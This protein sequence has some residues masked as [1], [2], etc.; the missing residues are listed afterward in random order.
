[1][2]GAWYDY[3]NNLLTRLVAESEG[4][5]SVAS[6]CCEAFNSH[7][8]GSHDHFQLFLLRTL[9]PPS[10]KLTFPPG[11]HFLFLGIKHTIQINKMPTKRELKQKVKELEARLGGGEQ[12]PNETQDIVNWLYDQISAPHPLKTSTETMM[13]WLQVMNAGLST[14]N[15]QRRMSRVMELWRQ[16]RI[17]NQT[18]TRQEQEEYIAQ[19]T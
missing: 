13:M 6:Q 12:A 8:H 11:A 4:T 7:Q 19:N 2:F 5:R 14:N 16:Q 1:L 15:H 3:H 17:P 9:F 10:H 18:Y